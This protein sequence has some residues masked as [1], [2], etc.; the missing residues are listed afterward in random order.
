MYCPE[1]AIDDEAA[2]QLLEQLLNEHPDIYDLGLSW[3]GVFTALFVRDDLLRRMHWFLESTVYWGNS[4]R[5]ES[6]AVDHDGKKTK[7]IAG[8][9]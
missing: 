8:K 6:S 1:F 3:G 7:G 5:L 4:M 2:F 9:I